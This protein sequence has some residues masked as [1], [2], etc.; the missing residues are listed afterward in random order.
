MAWP[1]AIT[2]NA[3]L[4]AHAFEPGLTRLLE[5]G[6]SY[7]AMHASVSQEVKQWLESKGGIP[8]ADDVLNPLDFAIPAVKLFIARALES[9]DPALAANYLKEYL[10]LMHSTNAKLPAPEAASGGTLAKVTIRK[11]CLNYFTRKRPGA[12]FG[13]R[14]G[15]E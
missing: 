13:D 5:S 15:L 9:R 14:R 2:T 10:R 4:I 11:Q 7:T 6:D 12:V 3:D 8:D 1:S